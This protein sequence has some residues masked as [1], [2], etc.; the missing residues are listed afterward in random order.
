M[1]LAATSLVVGTPAVKP[2]IPMLREA[3][4]KATSDDERSSLSLLLAHAEWVAEDGPALKTTSASLLRQYPDS[5]TAIGLAGFSDALLKDWKDWD[6]MLDS[7][8]A[9]HSDDEQLLRMKAE[10]ANEEG[11]FALTRATVQKIIDAGK[12]TANDYNLYAWSALFD[13]KLDADVSRAAQQ[14]SMLTQNASFSV[15]H[16]LACIYAAQGKTAEAGELLLKAM[17]SENLIEP[18]EAV[19][20]GYGLI[21]EQY[22][23]KDAAIEAYR[24]VE[25]PEGRIGPDDTYVLAQ[26]RLKALG[27]AAR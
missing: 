12:A 16:T 27:A 6:Q 5:Y 8:I 13:G 14:A 15:L 25:R 22:G 7:R 20:F 21:Y 26:V 17:T 19:W 18:N 2:L 24:K 10:E 11:N 1:R 9:K 3:L 4:A 23:V